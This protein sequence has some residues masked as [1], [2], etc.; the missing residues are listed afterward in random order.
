MVDL[1]TI[2]SME[3][4]QNLQNTKSR[5]SLF[6]SMKENFT[7]MGERTLRRNILQPSTDAATI[8]ERYD[9]VTELSTKQEMFSAT[10]AGKLYRY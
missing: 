4:I 10:Q 2:S 6:G 3:L 9:A 5:D 1:S 7:K 8:Q